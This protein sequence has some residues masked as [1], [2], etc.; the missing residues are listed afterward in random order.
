[1]SVTSNVTSVPH[2]EAALTPEPLRV[3][4]VAWFAVRFCSGRFIE[5][6]ESTRALVPVQASAGPAASAHDAG[7]AVGELEDLNETA[8]RREVEA[9]PAPLRLAVF[10]F[11]CK[12]MRYLHIFLKPFII[13]FIIFF[14]VCR[15]DGAMA[16]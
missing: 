14:P 10:R 9:M 16:G 13:H 1:M 4:L 3:Q 11:I 8:Y 5:D 6:A 12:H 7:V 15:A 2:S